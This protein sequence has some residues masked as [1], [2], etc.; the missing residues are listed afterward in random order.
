MYTYF[1]ICVFHQLLEDPIYSSHNKVHSKCHGVGEF[2]WILLHNNLK[3]PTFTLCLKLR[4][5]QL[6]L[7]S[8]RTHLGAVL[9]LLLEIM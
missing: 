8:S 4:A 9:K 1:I 5:P 7:Q 3:A 2:H 6:T